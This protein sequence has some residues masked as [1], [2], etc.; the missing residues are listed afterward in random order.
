MDVLDSVSMCNSEC[1]SADI[2]KS[3]RSD[4]HKRM[5]DVV[6]TTQTSADNDKRVN[7]MAKESNINGTNVCRE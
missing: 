7:K 2:H 6:Y 4:E 1:F 5:H 3:I